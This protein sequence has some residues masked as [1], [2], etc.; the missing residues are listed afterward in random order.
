MT[1][2]PGAI[3]GFLLPRF[4]PPNEM[5]VRSALMIERPQKITLAEMRASATSSNCRSPSTRP[6]MAGGDGSAGPAR[7]AGWADKL[8]RIG[9][10]RA[11]NRDVE[12]AFNPDGKDHHWGRRKLA[13]DR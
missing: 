3:R 10:M 11:L 6:R 2:S 13:R 12:R 4:A 1:S 5:R 8:A 9:I 7:D